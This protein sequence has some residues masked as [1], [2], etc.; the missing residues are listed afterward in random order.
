VSDVSSWLTQHAAGERVLGV[1]LLKYFTDQR[2]RIST[3]LADYTEI[4]TATV[5]EVLKP[6]DEHKLLVKAVDPILL[7]LMATG[8]ASKLAS[9]PKRKTRKDDDALK[10][11][12]PFELPDEIK[13]AIQGALTELEG[14]DYWQAIQSTTSEHLT[15]LVKGGIEKGWNGW[16]MKEEINK[17]LGGLAKMRAAAIA[18]TETTGVFNAGHQTVYDSLA[19][20]GLITGKQ[21]LAIENERTRAD[22]LASHNQEVAAGEDFT[23]GGEKTPYPGWHGLSARQRVNC[24][25]TTVAVI[26][27]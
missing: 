23:V 19:A 21:W 15:E 1:A 26:P 18:R 20:D 5:A 6:A 7:K 8:A 22:H 3:A 12:E 27:S 11:L 24:R 25:C 10:R 14:E 16:K 17:A 2:K 4:T 9:V 13:E